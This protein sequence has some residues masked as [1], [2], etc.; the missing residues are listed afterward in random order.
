MAEDQ[1][2]ILVLG[3]HPDDAEIHMGGTLARYR[4][5]GHEVKVVSVTNGQSGHHVTWG[6]ELVERRTKELKASL[7]IIGAQ[8]EV[9]EYPDGALTP[10][11]EVRERVI[12]EIRTFKPDVLFTHRTNDYHPDHRAVGQAVQDASYMVTVPAV[13]S[14][15]PAIV[16]DCVVA[17]MRD[18]FTKPTP[19]QADVVVDVTD[20]IDTVFDMA[21]EHT[22]QVYEWL[23]YN[24]GLDESQVPSDDAGRRAWLRGHFERFWTEFADKYRDELI[25]TYGEE[26][27]AAIQYAEGFEISEYAADMSDEQKR[28]L[29]PF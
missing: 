20:Q 25:E 5:Q 17:Y 1:L 11:L 15:T 8:A 13:A 3:A 14:D 4:E 29:F 12:R 18:R 6:P 22:S 16:K 7:D 9:W 27:G 21:H 19:L 23:A 2:K 28:R 26:K 24:W 10:T